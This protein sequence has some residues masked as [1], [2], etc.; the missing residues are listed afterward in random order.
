MQDDRAL[1]RA[2]AQL[3]RK[4][5]SIYAHVWNAPGWKYIQPLQDA[6]GD[7]LRAEKRLTSPRRIHAER[8]QDYQV[9]ASEL[10]E[11]NLALIVKCLQARDAVRQ[12]YPDDMIDWREFLHVPNVIDQKPGLPSAP[13]TSI[14]QEGEANTA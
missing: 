4:N 7:A 10:V 9:I 11:D 2:A 14:A 1:T 12:R 6:Q 3:E 8:G 13:T 5:Q